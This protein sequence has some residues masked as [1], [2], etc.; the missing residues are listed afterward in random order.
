MKEEAYISLLEQAFK[1]LH[2]CKA[3][4]KATVPIT[5][6]FEGEIVWDGDVEVFELLGHPRT[7]TGFAWASGMA[8]EDVVTVLSIPPTDTALKALQAWIASR[9]K[10]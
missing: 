5:E 6:R 9:E 10:S 1:D 4:H 3:I 8:K 7:R 2:D